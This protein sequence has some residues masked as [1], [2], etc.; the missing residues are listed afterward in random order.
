MT[1]DPFSECTE[2][3]FFYIFVSGKTERFMVL[4]IAALM[5]MG[6]LSMAVFQ[7]FRNRRMQEIPD[8]RM[9]FLPYYL[10]VDSGFI[11]S[12]V[13][14]G[15]H[16]DMRLPMD[17]Y[18][19]FLPLLFMTSS[20][21]NEK[22]MRLAARS[23]LVAEIMMSLYYL[24]CALGFL[25]LPD[26]FKLNKMLGLGSLYL[27][28]TYVF[29]IFMRIREVRLVMKAGNVWSCLTLA[30]D[31]VYLSVM[32]SLLLSL[33]MYFDHTWAR[34]TVSVFMWLEVVA[35]SARISNDSVFIF[36]SR[37]ER[38]IV[39]S[40][41][42]SSVEISPGGLKADDGYKEIYER[43][44]ALFENDRMYL[45]SSL[46][47]NDVVK[48]VFT[49]KLYISRAISQ[50][51]GRN[52]CQFVNYYRVT[53]SVRTFRDNPD[54]KV[55]ELALMSG[56]NSVVSFS[57]AFRLYMGESPSDWCRKERSR[58]IRRKK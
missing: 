43:I 38:R 31:G 5:L 8:E 13:L 47:I 51:T 14:A 52:F 56:F 28:A 36:W 26:R 48:V 29:T 15:G 32:M 30:I 57:M 1:N 3:G 44:V 22:H 17:I 34:L 4:F 16:L 40:M 10:I 23:V 53:Y 42:I 55:A 20:T 18:M 45:N 33:V 9:K 27:C 46:T 37:Q 39:E 49:N 35:L 25:P 41:K 19:T 24:S 2:K 12:D 21:M 7:I 6:V 11:L 58:L 54:L 50:F